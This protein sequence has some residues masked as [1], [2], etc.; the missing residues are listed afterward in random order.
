MLAAGIRLQS[1]AKS[2]IVKVLPLVVLIISLD[3]AVTLAYFARG[4]AD[5]T[6]V[7]NLTFSLC[8]LV[9]GLLCFDARDMGLQ[10]TGDF[11][12]HV[13]F[14]LLPLTGILLL[15]AVGTPLS[16]IDLAHLNRPKN[17]VTGL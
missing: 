15:N 8:V 4:I 11:S 1:V 9:G 14:S 13:G 5:P 7:G 17:L 10:L 6:L 12:R 3:I 16:A 2:A